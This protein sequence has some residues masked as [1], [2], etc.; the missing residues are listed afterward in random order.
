MSWKLRRIAGKHR[1]Q[2]LAPV[3]VVVLASFSVCL[4]QS[5][6]SYKYTS[7]SNTNDGLE[8]GNLNQVKLDELKIVAATR[9]ILNGSYPNVHSLLIFRHGRLVYENY[10]AGD[11]VERGVGPLGVVKHSRDTLHDIRSISKSVV[12]L[13]VLVAHSQGKIKSLDQNLKE[14]FP[15]YADHFA[16]GKEK[17]TVKHLLSMRSGIDW[18]EK[19]SYADPK[20]SEIQMNNSANA[21]EFVL[22]QKMATTPGS[23]FNYG[24]GQTQLL[25]ALVKK[26]TGMDADAFVAK[27][28]FAPLGITKF[29]WV[30]T[31]SGD[32]S[33]A[34]GLRMRSRDLGKL[35]LLV[36]NRG[37]W[38]GKQIIP[39]RLVDEALSESVTIEKASDFTEAYGY[40]IWLPSFLVNGKWVHLK[41]FAGN[42]GQHVQIDQAN[43]IMVVTTAGNY[44]ASEVKKSP[45][46][47]IEDFVYPAMLDKLVERKP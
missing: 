39:A 12:A 38:R 45:Q 25:V 10:F 8:T 32:P 4:A 1:G 27:H 3:L 35:G 43:G 7:P 2:L 16:G 22:S 6:T 40:Q 33:G 37:K 18:N 46:I 15:E 44:N 31:K 28:L 5:E 34:S 47:I 30:K 19:I 20:N 42:G 9:E 13:A 23:T 21:V 11:D 17:V 41:E 29:K 36:M 14:F 26:A 24:G